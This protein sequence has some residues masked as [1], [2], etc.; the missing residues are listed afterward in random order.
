VNGCGISELQS[1]LALE[2]TL[3]TGTRL[4]LTLFLLAVIAGPSA[5]LL[6]Q[7]SAKA[8][9]EV[10][11]HRIPVYPP[12]ARQARIQGSVRLRLMTNGHAVT[13]VVV[14]EGHP[15]L[16][17]SAT[18]SVRTWKF[19]DHVPGAFDV[20]FDFRL[21]E[22]ETFLQQP[23]IIEVIAEPGSGI[24]KY[25]LPE[26][27]NARVRNAHVTVDTTLTL[28]TYN[29]RF[30]E[31]ISEM[32]GYTTGPQGHERSLRQ[33]HI[34]GDMLGFDATLDD[35]HGQRLKF[36]MIGKMNRDKIKGVFLDY[37]GIGGT[38]TAE[39]AA[40]VAS[41]EKVATPGN[42]DETKVALLDVAYHDRPQYPSLAIEAGIQG[43]VQLR[44][45][46]NGS[47]V[48]K[49]DV[50]SGNP[51]LVGTAMDNVRSWRFASYNQR[52]FEVIYDYQLLS[53]KVEFFKQPGVVKIEGTLPMVNIYT[54][55][56]KIP[57]SLWEARMSSSRG[58]ASATL[59]LAI[60]EKGSDGSELGELSGDVV[61]PAGR[62]EKIRDPHFDEDMLGFDATMTGP[63]DKPL[64]I[65]LLGKKIGNSMTG[66]FLDYSGTPG[67]WIAVRQSSHSKPPQ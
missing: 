32:N 17:R 2:S 18:D 21:P 1:S 30:L 51:F 43:K 15:L 58:K 63:D 23:G 9:P 57:S 13:D 10:T 20:T 56:L 6:A 16:T 52:T 48:G 40:K 49:I 8:L 4:R 38:W 53:S 37:W 55:Q 60:P 26:N 7:E 67:T 19:V 50:E 34:D 28:W 45:T 3:P 42:A 47:R 59:S 14:L 27:W 22:D 66:V 44:V 36:S 11:E 41:E 25:T 24:D 65:S 12:L 64:K 35:K 5:A 46:T 29:Y 39:R 31:P 33:A 61:G 62:R 54:G